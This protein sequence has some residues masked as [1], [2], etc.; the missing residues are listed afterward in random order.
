MQEVTHMEVDDEGPVHQM[1]PQ[2]PYYTTPMEVD[3]ENLL[4]QT[5]MNSTKQWT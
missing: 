1:I 3:D 2:K 5:E 4:H